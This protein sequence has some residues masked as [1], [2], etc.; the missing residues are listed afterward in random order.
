MDAVKHDNVHATP[1]VLRGFTNSLYRLQLQN[2][3][4]RKMRLLIKELILYDIFQALLL[5]SVC[6]QCNSLQRENKKLSYRKQIA[7]KL[8]NGSR[9]SVDVVTP[10]L[11]NLGY[12]SLKVIETGTIRKPGCGFL[13]VFFS[14]YGAILYRFPD[15]ASYWSKIAKKIIFHTYLAPLQG[16]TVGISPICLISYS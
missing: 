12:R 9:T 10:W 7:R 14:N 1:N 4:R 8:R 3:P 5:R 11:W 2:V 15:I 13:F 6:G 16:M